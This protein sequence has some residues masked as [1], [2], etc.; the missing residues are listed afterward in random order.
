MLTYQ[1]CLLPI[2]GLYNFDCSDW[3]LLKWIFSTV[4]SSK[5][6]KF[7]Y[8][9]EHVHRRYNK[10]FACYLGCEALSSALVF[11]VFNMTDHLLNYRFYQYGIRV[12][13]YYQLLLSGNHEK[14]MET[15]PMCHTFPRI[16]ACD[17]HR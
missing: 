3:F 5:I 14:Y 1:A 17:Y 9:M 13:N 16:A 8:Y 4:T 12:W 11:L 10:Y 7:Q 6:Q 2:S 15:N